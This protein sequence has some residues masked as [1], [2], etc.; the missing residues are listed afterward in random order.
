MAPAGGRSCRDVLG[1]HSRRQL[2][3]PLGG[4]RCSPS[5]QHRLIANTADNTE[6]ASC[7]E[8]PRATAVIEDSDL[9]HRNVLVLRAT[10][11][12]D[13]QFSVLDKTGR[14]IGRVTAEGGFVRWKPARLALYDRQHTPVLFVEHVE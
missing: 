9:L 7:P 8:A 3:D 4:A 13:A 11:P 12:P 2:A 10:A 1:V 14:E 6:V 5:S